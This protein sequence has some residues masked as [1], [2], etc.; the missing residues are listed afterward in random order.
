MRLPTTLLAFLIFAAAATTASGDPAFP[1]MS[2]NVRH[3]GVVVY[4]PIK[5]DAATFNATMAKMATFASLIKTTVLGS[6]Y[7]PTSNTTGAQTTQLSIGIECGLD[8]YTALDEATFNARLHTMLDF[9]LGQ[10]FAVHL[11]LPLHYPPAMAWNGIPTSASWVNHVSWTEIGGDYIPYP[12]LPNATGP[13]DTISQLFQ[14]KVINDLVAKGYAARLAVIYVAN[15]FDLNSS[16]NLD[17]AGWPGCTTVQCK[18]E[19]IAYITNRVIGNARAAAK[20]IVPVGIKFHTIGA[21]S[22]YRDPSSQ[23]GFMLGTV[24]KEKDVV[25]A[26]IY[27]DYRAYDPDTRNAMYSYLA[28][29]ANGRL[30]LSEWA[31]LP[32]AGYTTDTDGIGIMSGWPEAKGFALFA[33][34]SGDKY[35]MYNSATGFC[36]GGET[37]LRLLRA[38]M[39]T[40]TSPLNVA[41]QNGENGANG[42]D[43]GGFWID[44][45]Y[46]ASG[47]NRLRC[48][49]GT[50]C[51]LASPL[52]NLTGYTSPWLTYAYKHDLPAGAV[53]SIEAQTGGGAWTTL[54]TRTGKSPG[55]DSWATQTLSLGVFAGKTNVRV[56]FRYTA[57]TSTLFGI[58]LDDARVYA[59]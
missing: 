58:A 55:W 8:Q 43:L 53:L 56:R 17:A 2:S 45:S 40:L 38:Q 49:A 4:G 27:W 52:M 6:A 48:A 22:A 24:M 34:N 57:K 39:K 50:S 21:N 14:V 23:M 46:P 25:G 35:A 15:E 12:P 3:L 11:L 44:P 20:G 28:Y 59:N 32:S 54:A 33:F 36:N 26:D 41:V 51:T 19:T 37:E 5:G 7:A 42:W 29:Y 16:K 47:A 10:G 18:K 31:R 9:W 30:E 13:Y 1:R